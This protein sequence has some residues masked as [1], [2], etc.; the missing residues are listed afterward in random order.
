MKLA[1]QIIKIK[2]K[3]GLIYFFFR[4]TLQETGNI[5]Q[6]DLATADKDQISSI[7]IL[8]QYPEM[9]SNNGD[10]T[11]LHLFVITTGFQA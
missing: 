2:V 1:V 5:V 4:Q 9:G 7:M 6:V 10:Q 8:N 11:M 3:L